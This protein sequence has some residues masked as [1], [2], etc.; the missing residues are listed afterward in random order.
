M[1]PDVLADNHHLRES[2]QHVILELPINLIEVRAPWGQTGWCGANK[3]VQCCAELN[4]LWDLLSEPLCLRE[5][6]FDQ[7]S[8]F[9]SPDPWTDGGYHFADFFQLNFSE[10]SHFKHSGPTPLGLCKPDLGMCASCYKESFNLPLIFMSF[11]F[12]ACKCT[13]AQIP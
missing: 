7:I 4:P 12:P 3:V 11:L 13:D 10:K 6:D 1:S 5:A 8:A 9:G 2:I